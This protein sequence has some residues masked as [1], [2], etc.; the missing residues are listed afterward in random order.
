MSSDEMLHCGL[1]LG[2]F[3]ARRQQRVKRST[4]L[5]RF[6]ALYG[7]NPVVYAE[8]FHDLQTTAI[9]TA[10]VSPKD[11]DV[12]NFLMAL[13]FLRCY[14]TEIQLSGTFSV[15]DRSVRKWCWFYV[16]RIC[17]LKAIKVRS[18]LSFLHNVSSC[19]QGDAT[20]TIP[21]CLFADNMA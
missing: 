14:H 8:I 16:E 18:P 15:S 10:Q 20:L 6:R 4:N 12:H 17:A 19:D 2:G 1:R 11:V 9:P 13:R 7:S 21:L 5:E 3:D